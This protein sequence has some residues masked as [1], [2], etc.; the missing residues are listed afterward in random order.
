MDKKISY[1]LAIL[2]PVIIVVALLLALSGQKQQ[3]GPEYNSVWETCSI[4]SDC[5]EVSTH[6][7]GDYPCGG[8]AI[9]EKYQS[10]YQSYLNKV[11]KEYEAQGKECSP[12]C[13]APTPA[14]PK[15]VNSKCKMEKQ[16]GGET[17]A[18]GCLVAAGYTW[19]EEKQKCLRTWEESCTIPAFG[20]KLA[21]EANDRWGNESIIY[22]ATNEVAQEGW[23]RSSF[24]VP[25]AANYT[26]ICAIFMRKDRI[27]TTDNKTY[28]V[29]HGPV[30]VNGKEVC[31]IGVIGGW[32]R[33]AGTLQYA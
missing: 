31:E 28:F 22:P 16:I 14:E 4:D 27:R 33:H 8:L 32:S 9:N 19:C 23:L 15:C 2:V 29:E 18:H 3:S 6:P 25:E 11:T 1:A 17:D 24:I 30:A 12:N 13:I 21:G 5:I 10:D 26:H 20:E 7:C